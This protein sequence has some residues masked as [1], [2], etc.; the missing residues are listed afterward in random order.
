MT[1]AYWC[2]LAAAL[3]PIV[4][5]ACAKVGGMR[6]GAGRLDNNAPRDY[7]AR[8]QGWPQRANWAQQNAFEAF[9]PFAAGVIIAH[10]AGTAQGTIDT[11]ALV[12]IAARLVY[13][14]LYMANFATLRTLAW[15]VGLVCTILLFVLS[16]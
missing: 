1:I 6:T 7:L 2:V 4:W 15:T 14:G 13:G 11:L 3:M 9:A 8:L 12:F 10:L 5:T 16:A